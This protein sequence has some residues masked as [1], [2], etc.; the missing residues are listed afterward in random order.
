[1]D[2]LRLSLGLLS[3]D[4]LYERPLKPLFDDDDY[5]SECGAPGWLPKD[6]VEAEKVRRKWMT[7]NFRCVGT[8]M[9]HR[10]RTWAAANLE[11]QRAHDVPATASAP[12][13]AWQKSQK[14]ESLTPFDCEVYWEDCW[15]QCSQCY[16]AD[17]AF[18]RWSRD[19]DAAN[20]RE[21]KRAKAAS[22][23]SKKKRE[24]PDDQDDADKVL[25]KKKKTQQRTDA[26]PPLG[27]LLERFRTLKVPVLKSLCRGNH[28]MVS[29]AKED[30]V[31]RLALGKLNGV[32]GPCPRCH[33]PKLQVDYDGL[34]PIKL[35]CK[36]RSGPTAACLYVQD[37]DDENKST[38]LSPLRDDDANS[39]A[40]LFPSSSALEK[41]EKNTAQVTQSDRDGPT[42]TTTTQCTVADLDA[43]RRDGILNDD[44]YEAEL[45][46]LGIVEKNT[47]VGEKP[48][49]TQCTVADLDALRR[50]GILNDDEYEAELKKLGIVEKNTS[51]GETPTTTQCTVA[52]LDALRR[53]GIL[54]DDEY[55]T[56]LKKLMAA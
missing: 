52:D 38:K 5:D 56:E 11:E 4:G 46:K 45:K 34:T 43:L 49:T 44:E 16:E 54:T 55:E 48:T 9:R 8:L 7:A 36:H 42:T 30:L 2:L 18:E 32:P 3:G 27:P 51:V 17:R 40:A 50:D 41:E 31:S 33:Q 53:D 26:P 37:L 12:S 13:E 14:I 23:S 28:L 22:A 1:M 29:G 25:A 24:R 6:S 35:Q 19:L 47:S 10:S 39:L 20:R 21:Q 15:I